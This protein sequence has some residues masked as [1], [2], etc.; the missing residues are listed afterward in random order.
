MVLRTLIFL[1]PFLHT[2][3][4][5]STAPS[6]FPYLP[7]LDAIVHCFQITSSFALVFSFHVSLVTL[8]YFVEP[9]V[10]QSHLFSAVSITTTTLTIT[11]TFIAIQLRLA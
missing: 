3:R 9:L 2:D 11:M 6:Y 1:F 10:R 8:R 5:S 7:F 4:L